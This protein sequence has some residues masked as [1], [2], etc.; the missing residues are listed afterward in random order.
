[1]EYEYEDEGLTVEE[2][3][4]LPIDDIRDLTDF[5]AGKEG[6]YYK[7]VTIDSNMTAGTPAQFDLDAK[8]DD[9][10]A[11]LIDPNALLNTPRTDW[12]GQKTS[13][14]NT[15]EDG[16]IKQDFDG[17]INIEVF[18]GF[19]AG[20]NVIEYGDCDVVDQIAEI[21]YPYEFLGEPYTDDDRYDWADSNMMSETDDLR[22]QERA[23]VHF[24]WCPYYFEDRTFIDAWGETY[25]I[26]LTHTFE[27]WRV[28]RL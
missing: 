11:E 28:G 16:L 3:L 18:N 27:G 19:R 7:N 26:T 13:I 1:M 12:Y 9:V 15:W 2:L 4:T 10:V 22:K 23:T 17:H 25:H 14:G 21:D 5:Y 8:Y 6:V 24:Q 20:S